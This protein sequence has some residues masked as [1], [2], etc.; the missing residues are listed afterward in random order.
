MGALS[1][2]FWYGGIEWLF[3]YTEHWGNIGYNFILG[4]SHELNKNK[5]LYSWKQIKVDN[6]EHMWISQEKYYQLP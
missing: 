5:I 2:Y 6:V 4:I 1:K 3:F